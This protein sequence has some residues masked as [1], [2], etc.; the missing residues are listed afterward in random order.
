[1]GE[2]VELVGEIIQHLDCGIE[3]LTLALE[4]GFH[5]LHAIAWNS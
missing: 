4:K 3:Y 2:I 5:V 1:M